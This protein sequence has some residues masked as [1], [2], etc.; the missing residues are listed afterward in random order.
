MKIPKFVRRWL[1]SRAAHIAS[2]RSPDFVIGEDYLC[3]WW[4]IPRNP[5]FDVY[6]HLITGS[7]DDRALHEHPWMNLS[8]ILR[9]VYA[10]YLPDTN[11]ADRVAYR[12]PRDVVFRK[13]TASHR[14][15]VAKAPIWSLFITGPK[16]RL[17]GFHCPQGWGPWHEFVDPDNPGM[18]GKGCD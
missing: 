8:I 16:V 17:W 9:G 18:R 12:R 6:L 13:A 1:M 15:V 3:R 11:G 7:D 14:I 4:V 10:E 5:V 2:S